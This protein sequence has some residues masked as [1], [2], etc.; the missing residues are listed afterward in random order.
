MIGLKHINKTLESP[1]ILITPKDQHRA[2]LL[3][4]DIGTLARDA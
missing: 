3:N 2:D 4:I 1:H